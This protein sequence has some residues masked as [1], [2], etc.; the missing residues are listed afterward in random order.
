MSNH[1]PATLVR[2]DLP[3]E[4]VVAFGAT[5]RVAWDVETSGLDWRSDRLATCQLFTPGTGPVVI[6]LDPEEG[7]PL[8]L[9]A[10]LAD[11]KVEKVFHHAPFD[12]RFMVHT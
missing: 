7:K 12:L 3:P 5:P 2:A 11:P 1:R 4:L 8:G 9:A 10:L 6:S